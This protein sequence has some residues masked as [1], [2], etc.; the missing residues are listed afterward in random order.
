MRVKLSS[1]GPNGTDTSN[2]SYLQL[3]VFNSSGTVLKKTSVTLKPDE[4][5]EFRIDISDL[6]ETSNCKIALF[7]DGL[8]SGQYSGT[9]RRDIAV[10]EFIV[11]K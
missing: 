10:D 7:V 3:G 5:N 8:S 1:S 6:S 2:C 4:W 11:W 9:T